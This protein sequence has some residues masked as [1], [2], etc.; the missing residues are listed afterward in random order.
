[1]IE[2]FAS[3]G[4]SERNVRCFCVALLRGRLLRAEG[5]DRRQYSAGPRRT[6]TGE[7]IFVL[8]S[9]PHGVEELAG[10]AFDVSAAFFAQLPR[11]EVERLARSLGCEDDRSE[12]VAA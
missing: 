10:D 8:L 12:H 2:P 4:Y 7:S 9:W 1:V 3:D 6:A 5:F 11:A